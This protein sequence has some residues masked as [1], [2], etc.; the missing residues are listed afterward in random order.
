[1]SDPDVIRK[2]RSLSKQQREVFILACQ[3]MGNNDIAKK[4]FISNNT[5]RAHM[6]NIRSKLGL[7][8]M[9]ENLRSKEIFEKYCPAMKEIDLIT[10]QENI[11]EPEPEKTTNEPPD[12]NDDDQITDNQSGQKEVIDIKPIDEHKDDKLIPDNTNNKKG[13]PWIPIILIGIFLVLLL[14]GIVNV[15]RWFDNIRFPNV[16][17]SQASSQNG[18]NT[19][20][21]DSLTREA[22]NFRR[23]IEITTQPTKQPVQPTS[24][25]PTYTAEPP[26]IT[27]LPLPVISLPVSD[28]FDS[29]INPAWKMLNGTWFTSN[30]RATVMANK[31]YFQYLMLDD[32]TWTDYTVSVNL[33]LYAY[34]AAN[35]GKAAIAVRALN[36][37]KNFIGFFID[38]FARGSWALLGEDG[39]SSQLIS[40]VGGGMYSIP[41]DSTIEIEVQGSNF[42]ARVDGRE[43][44][45][46]NYPGYDRG[47]VVLQIE[48]DVEIGCPSFDNFSVH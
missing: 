47:G 36:S 27:P 5:V 25:P 4:L 1:M 2:L 28:N 16:I 19:V 23:T 46:V 3:G 44:Q 7:S 43:Y 33:H 41:E 21:V 30:G 24:I 42:I 34:A 48:C 6:S 22:E 26:T 45:R 8:E 14:I 31:G 12:F 20:P 17:A 32:P 39:N 18:P 11:V 15:Y 40:G 37:Q 29:G 13:H 35:Q 10:Q 9:S 38:Y